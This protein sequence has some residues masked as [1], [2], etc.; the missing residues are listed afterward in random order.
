MEFGDYVGVKKLMDMISV[1]DIPSAYNTDL[2]E[3]DN[4][5]NTKSTKV[6]SLKTPPANINIKGKPSLF[7]R[8]SIFTNLSYDPT[9]GESKQVKDKYD[10]RAPGTNAA[11]PN[12]NAMS[13]INTSANKRLNDKGY[14]DIPQYE[15]FIKNP[16]A[17]NIINYFSTNG[18][19]MDYAWEDF[20]Y[21]T[22]YGI[23]PNNYMITLRRF[24][25]PVDDNILNNEIAPLPDISRMVGWMGEETGN[26]MKQLM[27]VT[28]G[29]N[30]K[31]HESAVQTIEKSSQSNGGILGAFLPK[32]ANLGTFAETADSSNSFGRNTGTGSGTNNQQN[33]GGRAG[34]NDISAEKDTYL[35][36]RMFGPINVIDKINMRDRGFQFTQDFELKFHYTLRGNG[37]I[38]LREA[39]YD[40]LSTWLTMGYNNAPFWG[41]AVRH[42]PDKR[43]LHGLGEPEAGE[44]LRKGNYVE[45]AKLW[46]AS[47]SEN[48][49][50]NSLFSGDFSSFLTG[51]M[52]TFSRMGKNIAMTKIEG[53]NI[54]QKIQVANALLSGDSTG[55]WHLTIGNP[56]QPTM[57]IGNLCLE[58]LTFEPS[59][60]V[61]SHVDIPTEWTVTVKLKPGRP[62]DKTDIESMFNVGKG[63]FYYPY[64]TWDLVKESGLI[65]YVGTQPD[66]KIAN[67]ESK[68]EHDN[69]KSQE[70]LNNSTRFQKWDLAAI[71]RSG[72]LHPTYEPMIKKTKPIPKKQGKKRVIEGFNND[73]IDVGPLLSTIGL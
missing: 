16:T 50:L 6:E 73:Y 49:G 67:V 66:T 29:F 9:D 38:G 46:G 10:K 28:V 62:R 17:R 45:F 5:T 55:S 68:S 64:P 24:P 2:Q 59:S 42:Q 13:Q 20:H 30:W 47:F 34:D 52:N 70:S 61:M 8:Y 23:I 60:D 18:N 72:E 4:K 33:L 39:F 25:A 41:G 63:R 37:S 56:F 40:M 48:L 53:A 26:D 21:C 65:E 31:P 57:M 1:D 27:S 43:Q 69:L 12:D 36:N 44:A 14:R 19:A 32:L 51:T 3:I 35:P 15:K 11:G 71:K 54:V 22:H 58:T 7:D